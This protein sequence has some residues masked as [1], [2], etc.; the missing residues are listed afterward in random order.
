MRVEEVIGHV[1]SSDGHRPSSSMMEGRWR[2]AN[3]RSVALVELV[4]L[5]QEKVDL[6][7]ERGK[8]V[9]LLLRLTEIDGDRP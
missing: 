8:R 7:W 9:F 2:S 4:E 3:I 6:R 1:S 5:Q